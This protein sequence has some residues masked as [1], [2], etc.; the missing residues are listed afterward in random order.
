MKEPSGNG[1]LR[2]A[3]HA[4][5]WLTLFCACLTFADEWRGRHPLISPTGV[6]NL[7]AVPQMEDTFL[8]G[9]E[10]PG[11]AESWLAG[12]KAW[13]AERL[14]RLRYD[15]TQYARPELEWT[16]H[17][18]SQVQV[19]I[20]DRSFYDS[21]KAEYTVDRFLSQVETRIGPI[22]AVLIWHV[23]P[24]IG[25]DDRNQFDLLRDLPGGIPALRKVVQQFHDRGVKVFFPV[26]AWDTGTRE[27]GSQLW[28]VLSQLLKDIGADGIN[29]D[30][31]ESVPPQFRRASDANEHPLALEPQFDPRDESLAWSNL[32]WNDWVAWEGKDYP[33]VPMVSRSKWL[34]P[35]HTVN[36]TDRYTRDKTDSLQHAF[37]NG[38][39]YATLENLWGFWYQTTAQDAEAILRFTRIERTFADN[40]RSPNWEPHT[41]T[42]QPGVFASKFPTATSTLWTIVN[43]SEYNVSAEQLS[44]AHREGMHYYDLWHGTELTPAVRGD[45]A[46]LSFGIEG[47][48]FGAVFATAELTSQAKELLA[49]MAE[50]SKRSLA[51]YSR[52]WKA[53][54]QKIVE[55]PPTKPAPSAPPGM[56]RIPAGDYDFEVHGIEIEGGNDPGVDVQ[57]PWEDLPRRSHR[58]R[59]HVRSFYID[60]TPVTNAEFK[61]FVDAAHYHP[62]DDHNF[63]R[64][65]KNGTYPEGW[66]NKPVTWVSIEDAQAYAAW[67]GKRLPHE[68]EWQFAAQSDDGRVYPWGN[69][70]NPQV[71]PSP[72]HGPTR[73]PLIDVNAFPR[74][75]SPFGVLDLEGNV[76]Q[77][78][79]EYRDEHTRAAIVRGG[80]AY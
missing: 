16:Q 30:T 69:D 15:G 40:L 21:D 52:D 53:V 33:F 44:L 10:S 13:R 47:R 61:Q 75:A 54:P 50:R 67:A 58:H 63:L 66:A 71:L 3:L 37:F 31:L 7:P 77:W 45:R 78:T 46:N 1:F 25:V 79:D 48:G 72:D 4:A 36:V 70:W 18:F 73:G 74:S 38:Q 20:W 5:G 76:S 39:G 32:A 35:R 17:I 27:E 9:P 59:I 42:M 12:L 34:E 2:S 26:L 57:Y 64:D 14:T 22:D 68:W 41:A 51:S 49:F 62:T 8:A 29:F 60:R 65:W 6:L 19:L 56:I 23:Y 80:A 11:D 24:N 55:T 28:I 43:R